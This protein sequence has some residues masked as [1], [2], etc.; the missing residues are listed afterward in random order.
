MLL[1]FST[2]P[3]VEAYLKRSTGVIIPIGSMEQHGPNGLIGTDALC[4]EIIACEA[5]QQAD[6]L[7][8]P[9]ITMGVAQFNLGF[10]GT[11]TMRADTVM[12]V[13]SD[14]VRSLMRHGFERFF[15]LNGH[16]GNIAPA[17]AAFQDL[18]ADQSFERDRGNQPGI[19]CRLRNWWEYEN[20][21]TLRY[22]L[23]GEWEGR[24]RYPPQ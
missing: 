11:V 24:A 19:R 7:V 18:Y 14:Y 10:P 4:A 2:W 5:G 3:D 9:T 21:N 8:G 15:F 22:E 20:T 16:G 6:I 13:I 17:N 12:A 23:Y 1:Q